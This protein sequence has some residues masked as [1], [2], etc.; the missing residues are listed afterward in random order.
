MHRV[1]KTFTVL[2]RSLTDPQ[3]LLRDFRDQ[4]GY[5]F[6]PGSLVQERAFSIAHCDYQI[7]ISWEEYEHATPMADDSS[8]AS[9]V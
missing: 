1:R 8:D 3:H 7:R 4:S 5:H 6:I 9:P 2:E